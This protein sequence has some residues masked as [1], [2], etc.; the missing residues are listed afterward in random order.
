MLCEQ[1][2]TYFDMHKLWLFD[3]ILYNLKPSQKNEKASLFFPN[4]DLPGNCTLYHDDK[5]EAQLFWFSTQNGDPGGGRERAKTFFI[6]KAKGT[7]L[8]KRT[9]KGKLIFLTSFVFLVLCILDRVWCIVEPDCSEEDGANPTNPSVGV[10]KSQWKGK[11]LLWE[12]QP[13]VFPI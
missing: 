12:N 2:K 4:V 1:R 13:K 9:N 8:K 5:K 10:S 6:H 7:K 3:I 11:L